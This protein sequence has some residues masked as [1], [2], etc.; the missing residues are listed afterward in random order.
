M[1]LACLGLGLCLSFSGVQ[2]L[3]APRSFVIAV[4][5][6]DVL[7]VLP[8]RWLGWWLPWIE[9]FVGLL[10]LAGR[11]VG[12]TTVLAGSLLL[13]FTGAVALNLVRG[14]TL[15]CRCFGNGSGKIGTHTIARNLVLVGLAALIFEYRNAVQLPYVIGLAVLCSGALYVL[16]SKLVPIVANR[17]IG[18]SMR[19][20]DRTSERTPS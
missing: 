13:A 14:R 19:M 12:P 4:V 11:A 15:S 10:L 18:S 9:C 1:T 16:A 5:D 3:K 2:K 20:L 17:R 8:S 6:F 7:P